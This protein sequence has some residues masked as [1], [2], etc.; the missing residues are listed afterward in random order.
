MKNPFKIIALR[1]ETEKL[2]ENFRQFLA[3]IYRKNPCLWPLFFAQDLIHFTRYT[4][5]LILLGRMIDILGNHNPADGL[6]QDVKIILVTIFFILAIGESMHAWTASIIVHWKPSLRQAI[7]SDFLG[8]TIGH[9]HAYFQDHFAGALSRKISEVAES[10]LRLHDIIRFQLL[11]AITQLAGTF[12]FMF[13]VS[14]I[15]ALALF[16]FI[17]SITVPVIFRLPKIRERSI[18]FSNAR[19]HVTG[20]IVD[21]LNNMPAVKSFSASGHEQDVHTQSSNEEQKR[22]RKGLRSMIQMENYRR[23]SLVLLSSGMSALAAYGWTQSWITVGEASAIAS[24][25]I[26]LTSA[27]WMLG[28][29]IVQ[30]VDEAG[31]ITDALNITT[32]PYDIED[33]PGAGKLA[34]TRGEIIFDSARFLFPGKP[35]FEN[36]SVHIRAGE[37]IALVG[38]SGAGKTTFVALMLRLYDLNEGAITIDGQDIRQVTQDSLRR[39][40]AVIPQDTTLFHRT[41]MENIRYGRLDASDDDVIAASRRAH[42]HEFIEPLPFGYD[43]MVGE[44]GI[45]LSGG[46]RQR[47]AIAR[48]ILKNAPILILDEAT[49]ALDSE[50]ERLIQE[51]LANLMKNKTVIAIAH[52]LS[53]ISHMDRILVFDEG[54]IIEQGH[55]DDLIRN[56]DGLYARLWAMQSG[57]FLA[58]NQMHSTIIT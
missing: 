4:F 53:T 45:R 13:F 30:M 33:K 18:L 24:M 56:P 22:A 37:K 15:Y 12:I 21:M 27:T 52:R 55:H 29:G 31:Y 9:S 25:S 44:R 38:P 10:A 32:R 17:V 34:V 39:H 58:P 42:A 48:A 50:S 43:T 41:L 8:Y 54:K 2:P 23:L 20:S 51:S 16:I 11:F 7:R 19:A 46:Q 5:T 40:I 3:Y 1:T 57:G 35:V 6:P 47:I 14:P 36:L 49:S 28:F 26:M